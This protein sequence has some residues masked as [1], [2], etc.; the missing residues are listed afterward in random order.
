MGHGSL[1]MTHL[2]L[3]WQCAAADKT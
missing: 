1:S 2:L 3:C